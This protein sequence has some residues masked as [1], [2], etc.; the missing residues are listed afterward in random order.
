MRR[1]I[2]VEESEP[3]SQLTLPLCP[4]TMVAETQAWFGG[5]YPLPAAGKGWKG[6][7]G[8]PGWRD[9]LSLSNEL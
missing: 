7:A 5:P 2:P 4:M 8:G 3:S 9:L 1:L 6:Q